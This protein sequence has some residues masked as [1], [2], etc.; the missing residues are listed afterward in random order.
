MLGQKHSA[1]SLTDKIRDCGSLDKGSSPI[2]SAKKMNLKTPVENIQYIGAV[3]RKRLA[4]LKIYTVE[5]LLNHMPDKYDDFSI[6]SNLSSAEK[7]QN[8]TIRA[9]IVKIENKRIFNKKMVLTEAALD[10]IISYN[11]LF[12][13]DSLIFYFTYIASN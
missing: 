3:Y 11:H 12:F 7:G 10:Y 6:I 9:N 13:K 4:K 8:I 5:D 2:G 1:R